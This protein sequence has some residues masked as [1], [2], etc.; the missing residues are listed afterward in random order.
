MPFLAILVL[1]LP[2]IGL[3]LQAWVTWL[4]ARHT[5]D[6]PDFPGTGGE[7]A[8]HLLDSAGLTAVPVEVIESGDHYDPIAKAV[9]LSRIHAEGRSLAAVAVAAHECA[10]AL[11]DRDGFPALAL[12]TRL[13]GAVGRFDTVVRWGA[14]ALATLAGVVKAPPLAAGAV[15]LGFVGYL[16]S[17]AVHAVTLPVEIDASFRR[18]LPAL[19]R[20]GHLDATDQ[21]SA[22]LILRACALTYVASALASLLHLYRWIMPWR[23]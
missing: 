3:G 13:A 11:Q 17:V 15:A 14:F 18:A 4:L 6:R 1:L 5:A 8:R 20:L 10:H 21:R 12:R 23:R 2:V 9:R 22:R 19:A 7:L 16:A